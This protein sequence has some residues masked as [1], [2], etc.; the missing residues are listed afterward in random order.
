MKARPDLLRRKRIAEEIL[1]SRLYVDYKDIE[2]LQKCLS[3]Q[4]KILPR[5]RLGTDAK[6]QHKIK[7]AIHRARFMG[8]LPYGG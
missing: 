3:P 2:L 7:R 1:G 4:G 5:R 8:L 6:T